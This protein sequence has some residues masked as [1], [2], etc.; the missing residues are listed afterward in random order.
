MIG[1]APTQRITAPAQPPATGAVVYTALLTSQMP[2][3]SGGINFVSFEITSK[4]FFCKI[5]KYRAT[6]LSVRSFSHTIHSFA[7]TQ[8]H[9]ISPH[10]SFCACALCST[11]LFAHLL[12]L[13]LWDSALVQI[14]FTSNLSFVFFPQCT[15]VWNKQELRR[16][17]WATRSSVRSHRSL[18][19]LLRTARFARALRCAHSFARLLTLLTPSLV[20]K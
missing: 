16:K 11:H 5:V 18:V 6:C 10:C 15:M 9:L 1:Y 20:G 4:N 19:R 8:T 13:C 7:H 17:Y 12:P 2:V 3:L 14:I